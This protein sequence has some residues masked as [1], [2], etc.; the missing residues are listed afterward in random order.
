MLNIKI[1]KKALKE[2]KAIPKNDQR[3]I[4]EKILLLKKNFGGAD[5][6]KICNEKKVFRLRVGKFRVIFNF[7]DNEKIIKIKHIR[8]RNEKTYK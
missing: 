8:R 4:K 1:S 6:R 2:F 7:F 3:N 5:V